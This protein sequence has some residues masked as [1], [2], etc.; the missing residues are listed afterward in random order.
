[1]NI[2]LIPIVLAVVAGAYMYIDYN[3]LRNKNNKCRILLYEQ[4]GDEKIYIGAKVGKMCNDDKLGLYI[5]LNKKVSIQTPNSK[6]FYYDRKYGR[7]LNVVKI[8]E[9]DYRPLSRMDK[10][11][12]VR[13]EEKEQIKLNEEGQPI[14]L[15]DEKGIHQK[16]EEGNLLFETEWIQTPVPFSEPQGITQTS[17]EASRFN[18]AYAKRM[19]ER[20]KEK[21]GWW[22]EHGIQV[23]SVGVI[24]LFMLFMTNAQ[25]NYYKNMKE[26]NKETAESIAKAA[27]EIS[28]PHWASSLIQAVQNKEAEANTPLS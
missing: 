19:E 6:D 18:R 10:S 17:R 2:W 14:P 24:V 3:F 28:K 1:M 15:L 12:W 20:M 11:L 27:E 22:A 8:A 4:T 21:K 5:R 25:N 16:D 13:Y 9:D 26:F 7:A 23:I